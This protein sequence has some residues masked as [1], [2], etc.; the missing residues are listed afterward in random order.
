MTLQVSREFDVVQRVVNE[1]PTMLAYWDASLR[2][3][4]AND[5]YLLWF[6]RTAAQMQ[7]IRMQ[8][9]LGP[10]FAMNQRYIDGALGGKTQSFERQLTLASG[11]V[12]D[13]LATYTPD[14]VD[15]VVRGFVAHVTDVTESRALLRALQD[16][17]HELERTRARHAEIQSLVD[18]LSVGVI[19]RR[20]RDE[21]LIGNP[22]ALALLDLTEAEF[23]GLAP[24][25]PRRRI[26][27][28]DGSLFP[29]EAFPV[30]MVQSTGTAIHGLV[31]GIDRPR[32]GDRVWV[33]VDAEP[34]PDEIGESDIVCTLVDITERHNAEASLAQARTWLMQAV[35]AG[36][37][38]LWDW[39][40]T[41][42][43]IRSSAE[44]TGDTAG[45][46]DDIAGS[47]DKAFAR[48]HPEDSTRLRQEMA[49]F[50]RGAALRHQAE[51]RV[52]DADGTV[53]HVLSHSA[54]QLRPDG[55][56]ERILG[57]NFDV[58]ERVE[59]QL[60]LQQSQKLEGI[61]QLA[62]GIA[63]DFNN[64]MT[65]IN[66]TAELALQQVAPAHPLFGELED[67]RR[68][69]EH[70]A[71]LTRQLLAFTRQQ[72]VSPKNLSLSEVVGSMENMMRRL[73]PERIQVQFALNPDAGTI[74]ADRIE[75]E[76]VL[77]NLVLNASDAM[78]DG[79]A[80]QITTSAE[81]L[82]EE[83]EHSLKQVPAGDYVQ[84]RVADTGT[85][86]SDAVRRRIFEPFF[87]TKGLAKGSGLGLSTVY[88]IV[89]QRGGAIL[90]DSMPGHGTT[91]RVFL[92]SIIPDLASLAPTAPR[93]IT[94][95]NSPITHQG[96]ETILIAEDDHAILLLV[97]RILRAA[98]YTVLTAGTGEEA[99][100]VLR[101][102]QGEVHL[103]LTD[104]IMPEM[105]GRELAEQACAL[106][107]S[108]RVIYTSG[109]TDDD[110]VRYGVMDSPAS[111]L[112]KPY[113]LHELTDK[114]R[115]ALD[116]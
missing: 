109:H 43:H 112:S 106:H 17:E 64:I 34:R 80:L 62:G 42:N 79:G 61:G 20:G 37:V 54:K 76:Q 102:H 51:F 66:A 75:I 35:A 57:A 71:L 86:M 104:V 91:F 9:L 84:L 87:T 24:P 98:G 59:L 40:L 19:V 13:S 115:A 12:R 70:A 52:Q 1:A 78:P 36:G 83:R 7:G 50:V 8:D 69:G 116:A 105:G 100:D 114:V 73:V 77:L 39:D 22:A 81:H 94:P 5:A 47:L 15:G 92:P 4:Y 101:Q 10:V 82:G 25:D 74:H 99:L 3:R 72:I 56:P 93:A 88:G 89:K 33:L 38:R 27:R 49:V 103:L 41:T 67:I 31:M 23:L 63:H 68:A 14:I 113:A 32:I 53:R 21:A 46:A 96:T 6:G 90:V 16:K 28:A 110:I 55:I 95:P 85:G 11:V 30:Q 18:K 107:P 108:L 58:T 65:V 48:V 2:C 97:S 111:F 60:Q 45:G 26:I 29:A 44:I